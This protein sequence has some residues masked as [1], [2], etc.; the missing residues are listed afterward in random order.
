MNMYLDDAVTVG[1]LKG[2][3]HSRFI[4]FNPLAKPQKFG[5][6]TSAYLL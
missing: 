5:D 6:M 1:K 3:L 2:R 4:S